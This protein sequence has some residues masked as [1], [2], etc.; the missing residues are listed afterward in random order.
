ME[1][2]K[3]FISKLVVDYEPKAKKPFLCSRAQMGK[4][5]RWLMK[6]D[7]MKHEG[8]EIL[9]NGLSRHLKFQ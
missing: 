6:A 2:D 1:A 4:H 9:N 8:E 7:Y 3:R 5:K